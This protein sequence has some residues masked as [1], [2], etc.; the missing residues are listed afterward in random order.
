MRA[1][2]SKAASGEV[3]HGA[4]AP[5]VD[6]SA[7]RDDALMRARALVDPL[8]PLTPFLSDA[9]VAWLLNLAKKTVQNLRAAGSN[10]VPPYVRLQGCVGVVYVRDAVVDHLAALVVASQGR[11]VHR[12]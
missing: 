7:V 8:V 6:L 3:L 4:A 2:R 12:I 10:R 5:R 1:K 9:E 11:T